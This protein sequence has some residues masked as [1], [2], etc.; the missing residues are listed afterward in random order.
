MQ[1]WLSSLP[2]KDLRGRP[3]RLEDL[4]GQ[5]IDEHSD[6]VHLVFSGASWRTMSYQGLVDPERHSPL[7]GGGGRRDIAKRSGPCKPR[8]DHGSNT[9]TL[10]FRHR[11]PTSCH[12]PCRSTSTTARP[13]GA[14]ARTGSLRSSCTAGNAGED[15]CRGA[16]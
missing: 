14:G 4:A 13:S 10:R 9:R 6:T 8:L 3:A 15:V 16:H 12:A 2:T 1:A 5:V 7:P 11:V